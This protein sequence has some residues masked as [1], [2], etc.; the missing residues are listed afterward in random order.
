MCDE[1]TFRILFTLTFGVVIAVWVRNLLRVGLTTSMFYGPDEGLWVGIPLRLLLFMSTG[2]LVVYIINPLWLSWAA[3][4]VT[5]CLRWL[6]LPLGVVAVAL[7]VQ[8]FRA[9]G[10]NFSMSLHIKERQTLA[11]HGPYRRIRHPM[12]TALLIFWLSVSLLSANWFIGFTGLLGQALLMLVRT[13][14]EE[15]MM[16]QRFGD[17]Y[18]EYMGR[19]G[20]FLPRRRR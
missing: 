2:S 5:P 16:L 17:S 8:I 11:T 10:H 20:R 18:A 9:L 4:P 14:K 6:G 7:L 3:V 1:S 13:P 12:Y 19:T 15:R